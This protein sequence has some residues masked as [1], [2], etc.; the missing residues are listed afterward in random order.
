MFIYPFPYHRYIFYVFNQKH[1]S[2]ELIEQFRGCIIGLAVGDALGMP[3]EGM[4]FEEVAKIDI[5]YFS[6]SPTGDLKAGQWTDDTEQTIFLAESIIEKVYFSPKDFSEKLKKASLMRRYGPTSTKVIQK[7]KKGYSWREVGIVSDTC[8]SAM[9]S[10]PIGLVYSFNYNLVEDYAVLSSIIT[11][12]GNGAISGSVA[13]A[14]SIAMIVNNEFNLDR[15]VKIVSKYDNFLSEKIEQVY[16]MTSENIG[17]VVKKIGNSI[18]SYN[19]V[20]LA[21]YCFLSSSN[22]EEAVIKACRCGGDT[23]TIAAMA[24]ALSGAKFGLKSIPDKYRKVENFEYIFSL[25]DKLYN[26]YT[27]ILDVLS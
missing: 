7:L 22:F 9:R 6:D 12:K 4:S 21:F 3:Y 15:V 20:P 24:G 23:D 25:A 14:I 5:K 26:T 18:L 16:E 10:S 27:K 8:G 19:T 11:H 13:V 2:M 17:R 1:L